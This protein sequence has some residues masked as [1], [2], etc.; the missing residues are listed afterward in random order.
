M[1]RMSHPPQ[2][3]QTEMLGDISTT[4][5]MGDTEDMDTTQDQICP[6]PQAQRVPKKRKLEGAMGGFRRNPETQ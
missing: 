6:E 4:G 5:V 3:S 1:R 2:S